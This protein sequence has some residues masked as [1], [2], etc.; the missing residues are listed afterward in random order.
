MLV[1]L[2]ATVSAFDSETT[3][4]LKELAAKR[5]KVE[6]QM[7]N[8]AKTVSEME[9]RDSVLPLEMF[10][11]SPRALDDDTATAASTS[12]AALGGGRG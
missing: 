8:L 2:C 7:G 12:A 3:Q 6:A 5:E 9:V 10:C 4:Q 1:L 11:I